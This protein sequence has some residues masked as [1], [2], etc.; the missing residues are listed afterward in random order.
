[1]NRLAFICCMSLITPL[2]ARA[3]LPPGSYDTLRAEAPEVL[4]IEVMQVKTKAEKQNQ[5]EIMVIAKVLY[6]EH[7]VSRLRA[8]SS[9]EIIYTRSNGPTS[10]PRPIPVLTERSIVPAFLKK[11]SNGPVFEPAAHG[12]SFVMRTERSR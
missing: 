9:I 4:I 10:G 6:V 3:E 5:T 2:A 7:S 1:M 8:G 12:M 11:G